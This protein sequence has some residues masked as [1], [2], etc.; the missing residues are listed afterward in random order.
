MRLLYVDSSARFERSN[1]R[2]S[3]PQAT[4]GHSPWAYGGA[5]RPCSPSLGPS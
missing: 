3:C 2:Q 4:I 1:S 5:L